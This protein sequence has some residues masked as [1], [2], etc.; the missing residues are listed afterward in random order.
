M[1]TCAPNNRGFSLIEL[2]ISMVIIMVSMLALA[3]STGFFI[4]TNL[5]NDIRSTA[6][7]IANQTGEALFTLPFSDPDLAPGVHNR[8]PNDASLSAKGIPNTLQTVRGSQ[9]TYNIQWNVVQ[10]TSEALE[11]TITVN[12]TFRGRTVSKD[13]VIYKH[14]AI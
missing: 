12:Y 6:T 1:A 14:V 7:R 5:G 9:Q 10:K 3:S 11:V 13:A 4:R 2:L 8:T